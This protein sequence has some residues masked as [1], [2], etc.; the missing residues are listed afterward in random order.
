MLG[1]L[2]LGGL[3]AAAGAGVLFALQTWAAPLSGSIPQ[4]LAYVAV[5]G[6]ASLVVT[7]GLAMKLHVPE[8]AFVTSIA[9]KVKG[10]L[11]RG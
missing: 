6:I 2:A 9:G 11:G 3:G 10:K 8:A 1:G 5:G 4:A 7:F